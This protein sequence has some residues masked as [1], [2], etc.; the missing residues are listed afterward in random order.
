MV[1]LIFGIGTSLM[2]MM[3]QFTVQLIFCS[4]AINTFVLSHVAHSFC[5][6]RVLFST[7]VGP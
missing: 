3:I 4:N 2:M 5:N 7:V 6:I 1:C